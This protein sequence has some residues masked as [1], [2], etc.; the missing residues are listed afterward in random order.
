MGLA[1][2]ASVVGAVDYVNQYPVRVH[3]VKGAVSAPEAGMKANDGASATLAWP[4]GGE[5]PVLSY[6]YGGKTVGGYV[7]FKVTDFKAQGTN[8]DGKTVGY[9]VLRLSYST[10]PDGLRA[11]GDFTRR[12]CIA[13]LGPTFDNPVL[14]A[15]VN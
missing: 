15:N 14:P 12:G 9:P 6:D 11:T 5:Q 8:A 7:V 13:Y 10:Q 3:S 2:A 4:M 1:L